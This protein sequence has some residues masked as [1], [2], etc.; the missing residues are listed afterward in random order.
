MGESCVYV[1]YCKKSLKTPK[2]ITPRYSGNTVKVGVK[3]QSI[4]QTNKQRGNENR[5]LKK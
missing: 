5:K 2:V 3:H 1:N 4:N